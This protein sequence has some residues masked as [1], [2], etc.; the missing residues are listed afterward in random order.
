MNTHI[1]LLGF[2]YLVW[3]VMGLIGLLVVLMIVGVTGFIAAIEEPDAGVVLGIIAFIVIIISLVST[4][5]DLIAGWGLVRYRSWSRILTIILSI[6]HLFAF[7]LG[8][9][10]GAYGLWVMFQP[11]AVRALESGRPTQYGPVGQ[12]VNQ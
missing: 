10:L 2:L 1:K 11:E 3:G 4:I 7:P 5:P 9:A 12:S 8:T 6:L